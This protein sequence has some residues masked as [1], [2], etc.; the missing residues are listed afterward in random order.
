MKHIVRTLVII[1]LAASGVSA[2]LPYDDGSETTLS[3]FMVKDMQSEETGYGAALSK[4]D[5]NMTDLAYMNLGEFTVVE[6][7]KLSPK[8]LGPIDMYFGFATGFAKADSESI[9]GTPD[10]W[11]S[12]LELILGKMNLTSGLSLELRASSLSSDFDPIAW[13]SDPDVFILGAGLSYKF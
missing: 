8:Q 13:V 12:G 11:L 9:P 1:L 10:G 3:V 7:S 5:G 4:L 2:A 6:I